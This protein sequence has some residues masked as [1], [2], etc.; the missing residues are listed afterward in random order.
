MPVE[1]IDKYHNDYPRG[2]IQRN[3]A[4]KWIYDRV[5]ESGDDSGAIY[6]ADDDNVY[7]VRLFN[8]IRHTKNV[9]V[10]PVGLLYKY[11]V[12]T[13]VLDKTGKFLRYHAGWNGGREYLID[14]AGFA[15]SVRHFVDKAEKFYAVG[16]QAIMA[17]KNGYQEETFLQAMQVP[18]AE[19]EFMAANCTKIYAWHTQT[20]N[21]PVIALDLTETEHQ[22]TNL[23]ELNKYYC[24]YIGDYRCGTLPYHGKTHSKKKTRH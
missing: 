1:I 16:N 3:T 14:M 9:S 22:S 21:H 10:F 15:V 24:L 20:V 4:L 13:P 17:W 19:M 8:E 18:V 5:K 7:D 6:L 12:E 11:F 2:V 23:G